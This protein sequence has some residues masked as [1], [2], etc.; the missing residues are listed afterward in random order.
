MSPP[1]NYHFGYFLKE[2]HLQKAKDLIRLQLD[3]E[4]YHFNSLDFEIYRREKSI[5]KNF[6]ISKFYDEFV[7]KDSFYNNPSRFQ[8]LSYTI[9]KSRFGIRRFNFTSAYLKLMYY[10]LGFY[11]LELVSPWLDELESFR[12]TFERINT[13]YGGGINFE[14][15]QKSK[16]YYHNDFAKFHSRINNSIIDQLGNKKIGILKLDLQNFYY[17]ISHEQ[18][19]NTIS[20]NATSTSKKALKFNVDTIESIKNFLLLAQGNDKGLPLSKHNLVSNFLSNCFLLPFDT[21]VHENVLNENQTLYFRYVDD[22][23]II[24]FFPKNRTHQYIG[25]CFYNLTDKLSTVLDEYELSLN[26]NKTQ[27]HIIENRRDLRKFNSQIQF[28]SFGAE[29]PDNRTPQDVLNG[30]VK[31]VSDLKAEYSE[32]GLVVLSNENELQLKECFQKTVKHYLKSNHARRDLSSAFSKWPPIITTSSI[33]S[34]LFL[35][36]HT[37]KGLDHL[38]KSIKKDFELCLTDPHW[39]FVLEKIIL[40][41]NKRSSFNSDIKKHTKTKESTHF[42]LIKRLLGLEEVSNSVEFPFSNRYL[43]QNESL[44]QQIKLLRISEIRA[45]FNEALNHLLNITQIC[46]Y[47]ND[48]PSK[49]GTL[50]NYNQ[51]SVTSFL[52]KDRNIS[53]DEL[54]LVIDLYDRRNKNTLSHP[55]EEDF[56]FWPASHSEYYQYKSEIMK[57]LRKHFKS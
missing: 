28:T 24:R 25:N 17:S 32:K 4:S 38:I 30:I 34:I 29:L 23:I 26:S 47:L 54:K 56:A 22:I 18:L 5:P 6:S 50:K 1:K 19:L 7:E 41:K 57:F 37:R 36:S 8:N 53:V 11:I 9:P 44:S 48:N 12:K 2:H 40:I 15:P 39:T 3:Q 20:S 55:G 10:A 45:R 52:K 27:A 49:K 31:V 14:N 51:K 35:L 43:N 21:Y 46:C 16:I 13:F 33:T 42:Q